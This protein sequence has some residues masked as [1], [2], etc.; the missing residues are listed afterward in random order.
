MRRRAHKLC[1]FLSIGSLRNERCYDMYSAFG[2]RPSAVHPPVKLYA[3][4]QGFRWGSTRMYNL[5]ACSQYASLADSLYLRAWGMWPW[6]WPDMYIV[7][8]GIEGT[9]ALGERL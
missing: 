8:E 3:S 5:Y 9:N 2:P 4:N 1:T 6:P 7:T